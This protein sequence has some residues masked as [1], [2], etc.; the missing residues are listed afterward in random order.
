LA[1]LNYRQGDFARA[2][3]SLTQL[4]KQQP[5]LA[6]AYMLLATA[7]L[8]QKNLDEA[9]AVYRRMIDLFPKDPQ[10]PFLMGTLL[11]Q[12]NKSAEARQA[13]E[14][15][16]E[17]SPDYL[18]A[19][20]H[21]VDLDLL[22]KQYAR[23][24]ER[25]KTEMEKKPGAAEHWLL[26]AKIHW[27]QAMSYVSKEMGNTPGPARPKLQL[28]DVP[29]AQH[30]VEQAEAALLKAL[31]LN[32]NLRTTY[33]LLAQL[34]VASNKHQQALDRLTGLVVKTNDVVALMQI[35][36]IH[37]ELKHYAAAREA[38]E[39]LLTLNPNFSPALNNLAYLYSERLGQ[40]DKAH[41]MAE[42]ARQLLPYD[43]YTADTLGWILYKRGEY[44]RA[45]GLIQ[46]S[47]LKL[48]AEPEVQFHL[49]MTHYML[50]EEEP[51]RLALQR[52]VEANKDFPDKAEGRRR[53]ALLTIDAKTADAAARADLEKRLRETPDDPVALD[54][55]AQIQEREGAFAKAARTYETALKQNPKNALILLHLAQL[56]SGRLSDPRKALRMARQAHTLAP[57]DPWISYTLGRLVY[58]AE[59][60]K[61]AANLLEE[62]ARKLPNDPDLLYDLAWS[63][64][65]LGRVA[66]AQAAMQG[67]AQ[68]GAA[69]ARAEEAKRFLTTVAASENPAQ[70]QQMAPQVQKLLSADPTYVPALMV[71][72]I[73]QEQRG[74]YKEAALFYDRIL[75][76]YPLFAPA[77]RNLAFLCCERL[78]DDRKAYALAATARESFPADPHL[79][80]TLGI[81]AYRFSD[82]ARSAQLLEECAPRLNSDA[83]LLYYL[84]MARY[85]LKE[86]A[87]SKAALQRALDLHVQ[88]KLADEAK[89]VLAELK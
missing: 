13:F 61:W 1:E 78:G 68:A 16:L 40:A 50:G 2:V 47:V 85:R 86:P 51:A 12:Q 62:S 43:P 87:L 58:Q 75:D 19:L 20:E 21:I 27:T 79:A 23:A 69:F 55:L 4:I 6:Q 82:Y 31:E 63:R 7:Y 39:K 28:A 89:R 9:L 80:K 54:R 35:G 44:T 83:E 46:E 3:V 76:R 84:G 38:Y 34:Y 30:D 88:T 67:P 64:Y 17:L 53:L 22:D 70:A 10:G 48:P 60:Y 33:L 5:Q 81:L 72:A 15:S 65:S 41:K 36:M 8:A 77:T 52:A 59:D 45:L 56:Y 32:P 18:P 25:V 37:D 11:A 42:R 71:S 26:L 24:T 14:K 74:N 73:V 49:G 66:E 57:D 29:A